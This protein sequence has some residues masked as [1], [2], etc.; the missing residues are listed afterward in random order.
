MSVPRTTALV[1][2]SLAV[3]VVGV[4][5]A[6]ADADR[7]QTGAR[8]AG[9]TTCA[10]PTLHKAD[11]A[12]WT[13]TFDDEFTGSRLDPAHWMPVTSSVSGL[14][15]GG[16]G[17][18]M[19]C[20]TASAN[21]IAVRGGHLDL[22][23][24]KESRPLSCTSLGGAF[25]TRYTAGQV[26]S[27][28][29]FSQTYG[30]FAIRAKFPAATVAGLQSTLWLWPQ[31]AAATGLNGEIDV[32]EEYSRYA[33][34]V[35][36][37]L[38]YAY[39]PTT[40]DTATDTNVATNYNCMISNVSAFHEYALEW[41]PTTMTFSYD[42]KTCLVDNV[43]AAGPSPFDQPYFVILT[44]TLGIG[45]NVFDPARTPLPATTQVDWVRAWK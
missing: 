2:G 29:R 13:C 42:G 15:A 30:R 17:A 40:V 8:S 39:D 1:L 11:G 20:Y 22:T 36:P 24:R 27:T 32:A 31:D 37:T 43:K 19:G 33:D 3:L 14:I 28:R 10:G 38:H 5:A 41:T 35:I 4:A 12:A 18:S 45:T 25:S 26:A 23:A 9:G 6:P 21:N 16:S 34:R 44:Q 7:P